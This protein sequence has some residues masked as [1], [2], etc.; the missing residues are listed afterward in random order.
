MKT[1][2]I[3]VLLEKCLPDASR[4]KLKDCIT[5][6]ETFSNFLNNNLKEQEQNS[7]CF[8]KPLHAGL[9]KSSEC[10]NRKRN[11]MSKSR[12]TSDLANFD[13]VSDFYTSG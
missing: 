12:S 11:P 2:L 8:L 9:S 4:I 3:D 6:V 1:L 7:D 10:L 13:L 5:M